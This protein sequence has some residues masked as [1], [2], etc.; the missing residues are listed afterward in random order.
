[1]DELIEKESTDNNINN[2]IN[3]NI[4]NVIKEDNISDTNNTIDINAKLQL[5][6]SDTPIIFRN[7]IYRVIK[8]YST[9]WLIHDYFISEDYYNDYDCDDIT[10]NTLLYIYNDKK[11]IS[12]Y[13]NQFKGILYENFVSE[14]EII[15]KSDINKK[16]I[17][18]IQNIQK[19]KIIEEI[20]ENIIKETEINH[21]NML[22]NKINRFI[23][24]I[25]KCILDNLVE[26]DKLIENI[27]TRFIVSEYDISKECEILYNYPQLDGI[28][29]NTFSEYLNYLFGQ[30]YPI[31]NDVDNHI[32]NEQWMYI[33]IYEMLCE[34]Y[35]ML[36]IQL[37]KNKYY[38]DLKYN[39]I[40]H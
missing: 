18:C 36:K 22:K 14:I 9:S 1:M 3:N 20:P 4:I 6:N 8:R 25:I 11:E 19:S 24:G 37:I 33:K 16:L 35:P 31:P 30:I 23:R 2:N 39:N 32:T 26:S 34:R 28:K 40:L 17:D 5:I 12:T 7:H 29:R 38:I 10:T 27:Y 21:I 13:D 15:D